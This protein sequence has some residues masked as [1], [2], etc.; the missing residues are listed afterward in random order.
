MVCYLLLRLGETALLYLSIYR[1]KLCG[2]CCRWCRVHASRMTTARRR[3]PRGQSMARSVS[4]CAPP[5]TPVL[6]RSLSGR[7]V[8][9][10]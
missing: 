9:E 3:T 6:T 5:A 4:L 7:H 2:G 10:E 1:H 8:D